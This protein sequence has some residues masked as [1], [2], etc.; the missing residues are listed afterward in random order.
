MDLFWSSSNLLSPY[1]KRLHNS[2]E[3]ENKI[4][5]SLVI[6]EIELNNVKRLRLYSW[7]RNRKCSL[8]SFS[9]LHLHEGELQFKLRRNRYSLRSLNSL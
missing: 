6:L 2:L 9:I 7:H 1:N 3:G 8:S 4:S 5:T